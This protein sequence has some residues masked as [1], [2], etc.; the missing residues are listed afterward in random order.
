MPVRP[1]AQTSCR[2]P[3]H[4]SCQWR[5]APFYRWR[6]RGHRY[7]MWNR[8]DTGLWHFSILILFCWFPHSLSSNHTRVWSFPG[9]SRAHSPLTDLAVSSSKNVLPLYLDVLQE[10]V[11][12]FLW[13]RSQLYHRFL[14]DAFHRHPWKVV[15]LLAPFSTLP[16][17]IFT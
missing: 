7:K 9:I 14:R 4:E 3:R 10:G 12:S 6:N 5:A 2:D 13:F 11:G 17:C 1:V 16:C 15:P 8:R